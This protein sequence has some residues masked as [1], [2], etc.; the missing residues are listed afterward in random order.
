MSARQTL[1]D[2]NISSWPFILHKIAA[3]PGLFYKYIKTL[4]LKVYDSYLWLSPLSMVLLWG[5]FAFIASFFFMISRILKILRRDKERSRL[6]GYLYDGVLVLVQRNIPYFCIVS[7]LW[8]LLYIT[9]ISFS[10]YQLLLKL[11]AVWFTFKILILIARLVLLE[12]ITDSSG[13]DVK[14]YYRLKWLSLLGAGQ[15]P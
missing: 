11:I 12:R 15:L 10:N 7:M 3:I 5:G 4:S 2:Y 13:K 9:H 8:S 14:L 6:T 1:A